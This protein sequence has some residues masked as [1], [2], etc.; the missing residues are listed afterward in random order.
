MSPR[1]MNAGAM[2]VWVAWSPCDCADDL[3]R[4]GAEG[5]FCLECGGSGERAAV[6]GRLTAAGDDGTSDRC[7]LDDA[8]D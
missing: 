5:F 2:S 6:R 3:A 7:V 8:V 4:A 1:R